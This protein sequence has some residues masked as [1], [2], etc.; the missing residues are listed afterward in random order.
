MING[1][2]LLSKVFF[3]QYIF[4]LVNTYRIGKANPPQMI[5]LK[6]GDEGKNLKNT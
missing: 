4:G 5:E 2:Y 1:Y 6:K 3:K